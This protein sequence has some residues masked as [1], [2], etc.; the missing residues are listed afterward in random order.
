[1]DV[2]CVSEADWTA[3][4]AEDIPEEFVALATPHRN[5]VTQKYDDLESYIRWQRRGGSLRVSVPFPSDRHS[6][7]TKRERS[8]RVRD[9][10]P[11]EDAVAHARNI[12]E[13]WSH[14]SME[15]R[16]LFGSRANAGGRPPVIDKH[17]R[18]GKITFRPPAHCLSVMYVA[19][20]GHFTQRTFKLPESPEKNVEAV[21]AVKEKAIAFVREMLVRGVE[22]PI[23]RKFAGITAAHRTHPLTMY[24][25]TL[26]RPQ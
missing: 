2:R 4:V 15:M 19:A 18:L 26:P 16:R 9:D 3:A 13:I 25:S 12:Q 23:R 17:G 10:M 1:M 11:P 20:S 21:R 14:R 24:F 8:I 6:K 7:G 22:T 5:V